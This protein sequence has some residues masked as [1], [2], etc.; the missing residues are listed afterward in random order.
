VHSAS[1]PAQVLDMHLP[2]CFCLSVQWLPIFSSDTEI[3]C[4]IFF[5]CLSNLDPRCKAKQPLGDI[6]TGHVYDANSKACAI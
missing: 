2:S 3:F 1:R 5:F 6:V 4:P